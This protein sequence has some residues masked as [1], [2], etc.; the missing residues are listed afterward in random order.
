MQSSKSPHTL[1]VITM[2]ERNI[3][4]Y[5][6]TLRNR[7]VGALPD[8][9]GISQQG[10]PCLAIRGRCIVACRRDVEH[11]VYGSRYSWLN[12]DGNFMVGGQCHVYVPEVRRYFPFVDLVLAVLWYTGVLAKLNCGSVLDTVQYRTLSGHPGVEREAPR[13]SRKVTPPGAGNF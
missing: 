1:T 10:R 12:N 11:R 3:Q 13:F 9:A 8:T 7:I 4:Q 6:G 5:L 2:A